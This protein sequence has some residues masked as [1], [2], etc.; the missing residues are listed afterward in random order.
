M[1]VILD[2]F[3]TTEE[4]YTLQLSEEETEVFIEFF[5]QD[6]K[7][8]DLVKRLEFIYLP[9]DKIDIIKEYIAEKTPL[10]VEEIEDFEVY[11]DEDKGITDIIIYLL[12]TED[13]TLEPN[14]PING[15]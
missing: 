8:L 4:V 9:K 10:R 5:D 15:T 11:Y 12:D 1:K 13:E 14:W 3:V 2:R 7:V 6:G